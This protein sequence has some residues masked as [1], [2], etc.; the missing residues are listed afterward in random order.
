MFNSVFLKQHFVAL[1]DRLFFR[2]LSAPSRLKAFWLRLGLAS[3]VA[4]RGFSR[5]RGFDR[6]AGLAYNT[7]LALVPITALVIM[8]VTSFFSSAADLQR[9]AARHLMPSSG[10]IASQYINEFAERA[11]AIS[12]V[13]LMMLVVTAVS[14]LYSVE[15]VINDIW[16]VRERR[17]LL[18]K[19]A[20]YWSLFTVGPLLIVG[21]ISITTTLRRTPLLA[22]F[23]G[24]G[25]I[26]QFVSYGLSLVFVWTACF[27]VYT[28]LPYTR[29]DPSAGLVGG[30]GAGTLWEFA[31]AGFDWYV[32][33][34]VSFDRIYGSLGVI[35]IFLLW[36]YLT[37]IIILWGAELSLAWQHL[38]LPK[39]SGAVTTLTAGIL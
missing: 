2:G 8:I 20:A 36:L 29:V 18:M 9:L 27:L 15:S 33:H 4:G 14:L 31:R 1:I 10:A 37:W 12:I 6:A 5:D 28:R 7:L 24:I 39:G 13:S 23:L 16:Q 3:V 32:M 25:I 35:P 26:S 21:S 19:L 34:V 30:I 22:H 11:R 17:P 38:P